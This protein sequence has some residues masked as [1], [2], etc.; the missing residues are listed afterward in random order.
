ML[1]F[2]ENFA[3]YGTGEATSQANM[4][5]G[6]WAQLGTVSSGAR[7]ESTN[8][9]GLG[10]NHLR[11]D[12]A[13]LDTNNARL[14]LPAQYTRLFVGAAFYMPQLPSS[15]N[16]VYLYQFRDNANAAQCTISVNSTGGIEVYRGGISGTLLATSANVLTALA[17]NFVETYIDLGN[18][19]SPNDGAIEVRVNG[20]TVIDIDTVDTQATA[21][22]N[23]AQI[24][25]NACAT[26]S[27]SNIDMA[28][29]YICDDSGSHNNDFLGD[30]Q[31][32]DILPNVDTAASDWTRNTGSNDYDCI[33]DTT[34]DGDSTYIGAD[35][36][37]QI[38]RFGLGDLPA[39]ISTVVA[40]V[41]KVM[42]RKT[43]AGTANLEVSL[44][45]TLGS[46]DTDVSGADRPITEVYT[47]YR[48][49]FETDPATGVPWTPS[50]VN[51]MQLAVEKSV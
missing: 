30:T 12:S 36:A 23:I 24:T 48:D 2:A 50:S 47:Y 38:S 29:L 7:A 41:T 40:V 3:G 32:L 21:N 14:A 16:A 9:R 18:G 6:V 46:P 8:P 22:A 10:T 42:A 26:G 20:V 39:T 37:A 15:N 1:L 33:D 13:N 44:R 27:M 43:D 49:T 35:T 17:Y 45:S 19:A 5:A 34:P 51:A 28:D 11:S 25:F 31:W 4:L